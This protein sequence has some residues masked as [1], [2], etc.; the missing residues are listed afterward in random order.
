[1]DKKMIRNILVEK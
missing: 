1:M